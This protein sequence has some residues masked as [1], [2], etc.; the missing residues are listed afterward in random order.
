MISWFSRIHPVVA[1]SSTEAEHVAASMGTREVVWLRKL[2]F[3]LFGKPLNPTIIHYDNQSCIKLSTNPVFH[4]RSKHIE[5]PYHYIRDMVG[6]DVIKLSYINTNE[7]NDDIFTEPLAKL[8]I[9]YFRGKLG[10]TLL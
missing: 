4:N 5:I 10:M 7:Q 3:G 6:R 8:K 9:V 1:L 2:L